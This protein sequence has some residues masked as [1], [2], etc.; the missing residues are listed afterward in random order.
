MGCLCRGASGGNIMNSHRKFYC[1][2]C[3]SGWSFFRAHRLRALAVYCLLVAAA[4]GLCA[5]PAQAA[6]IAWDGTNAS[7]NTTTNWSTSSSATTPDPA[8]VPGALD[9]VIFNNTAANG[10][11]TVTLDANQSAKSLTFN[12][13]GT[14]TLTAGGTART[15]TFGTGGLSGG[16]TV[17][18][19][20]GAVTL[21]DGTAASDVLISLA[22]GSQSWTNNT[23]N[24]FTINDSTSAFTRTAG[25][26]ATLNFNQ[27]SSGVFSISSTVLP[28]VSNIVGTW[29][30][31]GTGTSTT[32]ARNNG[33]NTIVGLGYTGTTDGTTAASPA[34]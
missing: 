17:A 22:G 10:N 7:W 13:T 32:Y 3:V 9:D 2:N 4:V 33:S 8:A 18:S 19:G 34:R 20:A 26:G 21:G 24:A 6:I 1:V 23:A 11:E 12:N 28:N 27:A 5:T 31:F 14:T 16:I 25:A 15:L 29:A 30:S